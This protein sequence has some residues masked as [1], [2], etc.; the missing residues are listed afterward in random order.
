MGG[1]R[2]RTVRACPVKSSVLDTAP[3][4]HLGQP[5]P[6]DVEVLLHLD[7][8]WWCRHRAG[9]RYQAGGQQ[10]TQGPKTLHGSGLFCLTCLTV[11]S[12]NRGATSLL[13][14]T[15]D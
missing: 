13:R 11:Q 2:P 14:A 1:L 4:W 8:I 5:Y 6:G 15:V 9:T 3:L 7:V 10:Q 12:R